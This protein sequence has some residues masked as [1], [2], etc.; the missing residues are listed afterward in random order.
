MNAKQID[1]MRRMRKNLEAIASRKLSSFAERTLFLATRQKIHEACRRL[2]IKIQGNLETCLDE[3]ER[4][5][6]PDDDY[7]DEAKEWE[8]HCDY[9]YFLRHGNDPWWAQ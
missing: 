1:W 4:Y 8:K 2:N 7:F 9:Q 3:I 6:Q 5:Y